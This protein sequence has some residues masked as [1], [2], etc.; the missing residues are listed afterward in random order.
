M[1]CFTLLKLVDDGNRRTDYWALHHWGTARSKDGYELTMFRLRVY[2]HD[3]SPRMLN[4]SDWSP[5]NDM[6]RGRCDSVTVGISYIASVSWSHELCEEWD[7]K[8]F[9][10]IPGRFHNTWKAGPSPVVESEREVAYA[11]AVAVKQG[12]RPRWNFRG[13]TKT[14]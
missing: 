1:H 12:K 9:P 11:I 6:Q 7:I 13:F 5:R 14:E 8:W 10:E 2:P 4:W 3:D